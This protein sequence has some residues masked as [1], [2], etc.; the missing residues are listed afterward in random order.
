M[1]Y[2]LIFLAFIAL[3]VIIFFAGPKA[4][5]PQLG[6]DL[7][8]LNSDLKN[9]ELAIQQEE[10][11]IEGLRKD[12]EA[13]IV[14][15]DSAEYKKTPYSLVY[16]HGF[17]A[18]QGEGEPIH[19]EFAKRYGCNLYLSRLQAHGISHPDAMLELD[20]EKYLESAREAIAIG[21]QIGEK[22][23]V[24][25]TSTGGTQ[26]LYLAAYHSEIAGLICY[27]PNIELFD[28]ST[29]DL[30]LMPWGLQIARAVV[31]GKN[32]TFEEE[33]MSDE[34]KQYWT[35]SYRLEALIALKS[36]MKASMKEEVF[37]KIKQPLF[38]GYFYESDSVQDMVVSVPAMLEMFDQLGTDESQK[39]KVAFAKAGDHVIASQY[40]S[41][42]LEGVRN[43]TF[44]FA[45]EI[46]GL[47][48]VLIAVDS[49][50][51][52]KDSQ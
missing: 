50:K 41:Q 8:E 25:S 29:S 3:L 23:I 26:A 4:A 12:N 34:T 48:P 27:S 31:G 40:T 39:R 17:S 5:V 32:R 30:L 45:E 52:G 35:T 13:R 19:R 46:L 22:T 37:N 21:Q 47:E 18:S 42:D 11:N 28:K 51:V 14:W 20:P 9:L 36:L 49:I 2:F 38:L 43:E 15:A 1:K 10:R 24:M 44:K 7:P 16:L 33:D 6:T